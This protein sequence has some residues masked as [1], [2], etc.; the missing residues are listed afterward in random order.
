MIYNLL[1]SQAKRR[2]DKIAVVGDQ[3][4]LTFARL[5]HSVDATAAHLQALNIKAEDPLLVGIPPS[6]EFYTLFFAAA[7]L[8]AT[9]IPVSP[10]A[11]FPAQFLDTRP[12]LAI[13]TREFVDSCSK[14]C[15]SLHGA[16]LWDRN[17]GLH[18]PDPVKPFVRRRAVR[19]RKVVAVS[20]SGTS[21]NPT[22]CYQSAELLLE[23]SKLK[24]KILGVS[25]DDVL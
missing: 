14:S 5:R 8:G 1:V 10:S 6:P 16:L 22:V 21:G 2:P 25:S 24:A 11:K 13:G 18:L 23:R 20:S 15:P 19:T 3:R 4:S 12:A 17:N 9:V 7:A